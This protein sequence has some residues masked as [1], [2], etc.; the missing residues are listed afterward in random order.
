MRQIR[1]EAP[2]DEKSL[3]AGHPGLERFKIINEMQVEQSVTSTKS[4]TT[5]LAVNSL[6]CV[7]KLGRLFRYR[8]FRWQVIQFIL[9][10]QAPGQVEIFIRATL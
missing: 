1:I 10:P 8:E 7:K 3:S 6:R 9:I 2:A 4:S 5:T